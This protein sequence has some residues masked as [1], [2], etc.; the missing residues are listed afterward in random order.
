MNR[1]WNLKVKSTHLDGNGKGEKNCQ[2]QTLRYGN[3]QDGDGNQN[4]TCKVLYVAS[5]PWQPF[6]HELLHAVPHDQNH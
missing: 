6:E 1:L 2:R 3:D 5:I 4:K